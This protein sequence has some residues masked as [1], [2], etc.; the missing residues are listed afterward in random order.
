MEKYR[1]LLLS[2]PVP[3]PVTSVYPWLIS[4]TQLLQN[5]PFCTVG[6]CVLDRRTIPNSGLLLLP[7]V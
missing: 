7:C 4:I 1:S 3:M 5:P 2:L 6:N